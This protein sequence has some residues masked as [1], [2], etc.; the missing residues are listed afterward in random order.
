MKKK[1]KVIFAVVSAIYL[2]GIFFIVTR[3]KA[4]SFATVFSIWTLLYLVYDGTLIYKLASAR[5][6]AKTANLE[7]NGA[8]LS[9]TLKHVSGLPIAK[10]LPV[11]VYYGPERILFK[12]N[13]QEISV[14]REKVTGIDVVTGRGSARKAISGAATGKYVMGGTTGAA[15]GAFAAIDTYLVI[16]Y[17]SDGKSKSITLDTASSG[18]F[19]TK[20]A[21]DFQTSG[22]K[23]RSKIEL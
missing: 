6:R 21:K 15:L 20:V 10:N 8:T 7:R 5:K 18:T 1:D 16:S 9:A 19:S 11:T 2:I 22:T 13:G 4:H 12:S 14:A 23:S 3:V 17:T